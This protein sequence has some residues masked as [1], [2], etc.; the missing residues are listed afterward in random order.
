[1][2]IIK[3]LVPMKDGEIVEPVEITD[4]GVA[5]YPV[6]TVIKAKAIVKKKK[7]TVK[8]QS[9]HRINI[10]RYEDTFENGY[11]WDKVNT[12]IQQY[13]DRVYKEKQKY[14]SS[15]E[16]KLRSSELNYN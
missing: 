12:E 11:G 10:E 6:G 14:W 8:Q 2:L 1:M 13:H 16:G 3:E 4:T 7:E 9:S 5:I 15:E